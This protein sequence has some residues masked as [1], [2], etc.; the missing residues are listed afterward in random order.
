[1]DEF[2]I[3]DSHGRVYD[4]GHILSAGDEKRRKAIGI[5]P[6]IADSVRLHVPEHG[7]PPYL[8]QLRGSHMQ[9]LA[10][11]CRRKQRTSYDF[12]P[13]TTGQQRTAA[14]LFRTESAEDVEVPGVAVAHDPLACALGRLHDHIHALGVGRE[15]TKCYK[16]LSS[17]RLT[18]YPKQF[19]VPRSAFSFLF[20]GRKFSPQVNSEAMTLGYILEEE[21]R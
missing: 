1:M 12:F 7:M 16:H 17:D 8:H 15:V 13:F 10:S 21:D 3:G 6:V 18:V 9:I 11:E 5:M 20:N 4:V 2:E 19:A 14:A